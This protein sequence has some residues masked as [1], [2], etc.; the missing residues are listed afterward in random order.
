MPAPPF[1]ARPSRTIENHMP[2]NHI[3]KPEISARIDREVERERQEHAM[4]QDAKAHMGEDDERHK[5]ARETP[6]SSTVRRFK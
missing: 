1:V 4:N 2:S 5:D 3:P 6:L